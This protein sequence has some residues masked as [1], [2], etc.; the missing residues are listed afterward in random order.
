MT[1]INVLISV[2][3]PVETGNFDSSSDLRIYMQ[4][5]SL[6]DASET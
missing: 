5:E 3:E 2:G 4:M 1:H 6:I